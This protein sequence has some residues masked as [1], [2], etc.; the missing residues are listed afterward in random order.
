MGTYKES[1]KSLEKRFVFTSCFYGWIVQVLPPRKSRLICAFCLFMR[2]FIEGKN[3]PHTNN[4]ILCALQTLQGYIVKLATLIRFYF[5]NYAHE[6]LMRASDNDTV[7]NL[8]NT[9]I[10][11]SR[12]R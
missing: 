10:L 9:F 6:N 2:G 8:D 3:K 4:E 1:V 11:F 7:G 12:V 5:F